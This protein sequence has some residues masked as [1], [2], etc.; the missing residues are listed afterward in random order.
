[1]HRDASD[2]STNEIVTKSTSGSVDEAVD[3]LGDLVHERGM[4]LFAIIDHSGEAS[5]HGL[6]LRNTKLVIF[7]SPAAGTPVMQASPLAALDLPLKVLV[8]DDDGRTKI[9]Y[10]DPAALATRHHLPG[11]LAGRI[12]G[13]GPLTDALIG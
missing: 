11:E 7:G 12:A 13:I 4:T 3:R 2:H 1:M 5:R 9:S 8:W 6:E 10:T